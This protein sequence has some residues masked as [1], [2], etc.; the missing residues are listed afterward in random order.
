M[1]KGQWGS[2]MIEE[3][4]QILLSRNGE[5]EGVVIPLCDL[6]IGSPKQFT[7]YTNLCIR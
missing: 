1:E 6:A 7:A 4:I 3:P 5:E 2:T